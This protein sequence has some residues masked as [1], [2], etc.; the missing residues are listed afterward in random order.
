MRGAWQTM[1][2][3]TAIAIATA[4]ATAIA[5]AYCHCHC[6]CYCYCYCLLLLLLLLPTVAGPKAQPAERSEAL[7]REW[8]HNDD[9]RQTIANQHSVVKF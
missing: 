4:I 1:L 2:L 7:V 5:I 6:Y 8:M 9:A 3:P